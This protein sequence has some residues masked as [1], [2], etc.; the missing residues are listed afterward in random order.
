[1]CVLENESEDLS[2]KGGI[3]KRMGLRLLTMRSINVRKRMQVRI[4]EKEWRTNRA[5]E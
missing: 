1:M 4:G 5:S 3:R 2:A